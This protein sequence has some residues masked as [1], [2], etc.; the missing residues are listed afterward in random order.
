M[1]VTKEKKPTCLYKSTDASTEEL[2]IVS[3]FAMECG[4]SFW[5]HSAKR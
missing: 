5:L 2:L 3:N 4:V 1:S